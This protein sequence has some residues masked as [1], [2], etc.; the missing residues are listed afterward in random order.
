MTLWVAPAA[1]GQ[2][3]LGQAV[4]AAG[5]TRPPSVPALVP[6]DD[7]PRTED[8]LVGLLRGAGLADVACRPLSWDHRTTPREWWSGPAAGVAAIGRIVL[9]GGAAVTERIRQQ[10]AVPAQEFTDNDGWLV[11]PHTA[12]LASGRVA[13]PEVSRCDDL[14]VPAARR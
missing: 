13:G 11:L 9:S 3:L 8:G 4:E 12:L 14:P 10:F 1:P 7:F 2:V 5:V 6:E